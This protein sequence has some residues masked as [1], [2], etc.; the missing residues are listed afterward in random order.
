MHSINHGNHFKTPLSPPSPLA[1]PLSL[2]PPLIS[3]PILSPPFSPPLT[4]PL[5]PSHLSPYPLT[6]L[7]LSPPL[8]QTTECPQVSFVFSY[9]F[10]PTLFHT[11]SSHP[12]PPLSQATECPQ[13]QM[14][15]KQ[16]T[17]KCKPWNLSLTISPVRLRTTNVSILSICTKNFR[18]LPASKLR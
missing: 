9:T 7:L 4:F 12:P 18:P 6:P 13:A 2:S 3:P 10:Q 17:T 8:S 14:L 16:A 15:R 1:S 11:L 5:P